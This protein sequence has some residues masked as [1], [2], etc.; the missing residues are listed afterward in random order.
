MQIGGCRKTHE[1]A[2]LEKSA[3]IGEYCVGWRTVH[4]G[5]PGSPYSGRGVIL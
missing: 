3:C 5:K 1:E 4:H 2:L